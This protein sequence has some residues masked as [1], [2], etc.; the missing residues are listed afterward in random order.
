[1]RPKTD[2]SPP[3]PRLLPTGYSVPTVRRRVTRP[4]HARRADVLEAAQAVFAPKSE[5]KECP[6]KG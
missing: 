2:V 6:A 4:L 5:K 1:M 3:L